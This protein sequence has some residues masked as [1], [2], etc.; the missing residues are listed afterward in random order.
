MSAYTDHTISLAGQ[1]T[2]RSWLATAGPT[3]GKGSRCHAQALATDTLGG[4]DRESVASKHHIDEK[5]L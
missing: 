5:L 2:C 1:P 4:K 3:G